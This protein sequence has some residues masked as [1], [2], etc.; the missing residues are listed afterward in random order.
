[1]LRHVCSGLGFFLMCVGLVISKYFCMFCDTVLLW[2]SNLTTVEKPNVCR[3]FKFSVDQLK[4]FSPFQVGLFLT[5]G[6]YTEY[7]GV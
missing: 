2:S 4:K 3:R 5:D 6:P 7:F 1:M